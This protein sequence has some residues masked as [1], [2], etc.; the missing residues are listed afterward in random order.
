MFS[1]GIVRCPKVGRADLVAPVRLNARRLRVGRGQ[2]VTP[3]DPAVWR[4]GAAATPRTVDEPEGAPR[5]RRSA[6]TNCFGWAL[7]VG[8]VP[9]ARY[10]H[11]QEAEKEK[12][13]REAPRAVADCAFARSSANPP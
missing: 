1:R 5:Q 7:N 2:V 8:E 10:A 6:W 13:A 4:I 11:R 9:S 3:S 12:Q